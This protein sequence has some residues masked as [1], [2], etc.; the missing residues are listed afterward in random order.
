MGFSQSEGG[1]QGYGV[2]AG[3]T[4]GGTQHLTIENS[5]FEDNFISGLGMFVDSGV[6]DATVRNNA[7]TGSRNGAIRAATLT[8][9]NAASLLQVRIEHNTIGTQGVL[10]SGGVS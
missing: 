1:A 2:R 9:P 6:L 8:G 3:V 10:D 7:I 4:E 5:V